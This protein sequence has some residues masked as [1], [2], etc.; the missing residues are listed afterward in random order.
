MYGEGLHEE[1]WEN[2]ITNIIMFL[3]EKSAEIYI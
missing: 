3:F 1:T 2:L